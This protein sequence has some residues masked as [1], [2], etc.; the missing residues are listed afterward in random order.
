M[1]R[2][3]TCLQLAERIEK[4]LQK[5]AMVDNVMALELVNIHKHLMEKHEL[6]E[7]YVRIRDMA[8]VMQLIKLIKL[9]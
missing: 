1:A 5:K 9:L 8:R 7:R 3:L 2:K 4:F 6:G